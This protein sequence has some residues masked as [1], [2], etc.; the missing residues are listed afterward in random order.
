MLERIG[1]VTLIEAAMDDI[2]RLIAAAPGTRLPSIR[3]LAERRGVSKSTVVEAYDRL[4]AEG[5]V[6]ARP[7]SGFFAV[8]RI[9]PFALAEGGPRLDRA[10]DPLW[11]YRQALVQRE[12]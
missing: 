7:G 3:R 11:I 1:S 2:R 10:I 12:G 9:K 6:E 4:V 8:A 5:A